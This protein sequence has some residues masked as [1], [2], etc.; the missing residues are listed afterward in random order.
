MPHSFNFNSCMYKYKKANC[1]LVQKMQFFIFNKDGINFFNY[2]HPPLLTYLIMKIF[3][4]FFTLTNIPPTIP[5]YC[6]IY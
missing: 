4:F 1:F 6:T 5:I 2:S 3:S